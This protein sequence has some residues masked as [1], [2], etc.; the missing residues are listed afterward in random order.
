MLTRQSGGHAWKNQLKNAVAYTGIVGGIAAVATMVVLGCVAAYGAA[1][2]AIATAATL[3]AASAAI[4]FVGWAILAAAVVAASI[5]MLVK[6]TAGEDQNFEFFVM[7]GP[8]NYPLV[9]PM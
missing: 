6:L 4:P 3:A 2:T 1:G 5:Y 7:R 9:I 8:E